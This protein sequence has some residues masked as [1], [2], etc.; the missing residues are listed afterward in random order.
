MTKEEI[1]LQLTLKS[2][3]KIILHNADGVKSSTNTNLS[4]D[5]CDIYNYIYK[6]ISFDD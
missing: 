1:V 5:V 2:V 4:K 3:E 6:N